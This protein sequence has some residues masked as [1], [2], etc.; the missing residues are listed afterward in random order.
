MDWLVEF[1]FQFTNGTSL[2]LTNSHGPL[3]GGIDTPEP[4]FGTLINPD[5]ST[6]LVYNTGLSILRYTPSVNTS[7]SYPS[8]WKLNV[9]TGLGNPINLQ[10]VPVSDV[11][12]QAMW[13]GAQVEYAEAAAAVTA[14]GT[15][16]GKDVGTLAGVGYCES[17]GFENN[18]LLAKR[19]VAYLQATS[20]Q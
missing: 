10:V 8:A 6:E 5:G 7:A 13:M 14:T 3:V 15:I 4:G 17:V 9:G 19:Q 12:Q 16:N 20:G 2:T 11:S 18:V 1:E